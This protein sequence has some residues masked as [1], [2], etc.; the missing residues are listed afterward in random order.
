DALALVHLNG[1]VYDPFVARFISGD[2]YVTDPT[3]GQNYNRYSYVL[4]NPTN[5]TDPTGFECV[6]VTGSATCQSS[7]EAAG[8]AGEGLGLKGGISA[9]QGRI[10]DAVK[11]CESGCKITARDAQGN[12]IQSVDYPGTPTKMGQAG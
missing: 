4:N 12:V 7:Q 5:L 10:A 3:N 11:A 1:R 6:A 9:S 2:P 8:K